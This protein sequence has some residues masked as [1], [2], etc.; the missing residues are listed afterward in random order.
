M[1][2][3][4]RI[5]GRGKQL[6][7]NP[8]VMRWVSDDRVM[9]AAEGVLD[10]RTRVKLAWH[11]LKNGHALPAVDPALDDSLGET[12]EGS[13][14][15]HAVNGSSIHGSNGAAH[16]NG[17]NGYHG[18]AASSAGSNGS[19]NG[20]HAAA[21]VARARPARENGHAN[22]VAQVAGSVD[23]EDA[24]RE[25]TGLANVG[26]HDVFEKCYQFT[27][28]DNARKAGL[29]PF[30]RPLDFNDGPEAVVDG[31]R[32]LMF[33]S[34]NYLGLTTHP[35]VRE[36][37]KAAIDRFGTS[38]TGSR[39]VN[40]SMKLHNE[41]E[42]K[43]AAFFGKESA[44]VFTTGYQVNIATCAAILSN[45][46]SVAVVDRN[47]HASLYDGVRLGQSA[48]TRLTRFKH[49]DPESLERALQRVDAGEG[50]LVITDGVFSAEGEIAKLDQIVPI[51]KRYGARLLVDDAH[52]LGVIGPGGRGTAHHFGL[53][54]DVDLIG[55][56]FSKSMA[57]IGGWL[58]GERKVL[59]Y[60]QHF[61][62]SFMFAASAAPPQVAAAMAAFDLLQE[63]AWRM[64]KLR[65]NFTFMRD[66][67]TKMGFELG[68]TQTAVIPIYIRQDLRTLMM[69]RELLEEHGVYTN[70]FIS[71][72]VP[73]KSAMLRTSYMA[74]HTREHLERGLE[75]LY[76]AGKKYGVI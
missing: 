39:L 37:A 18:A 44:L 51:V 43:L 27:A 20:A 16:V 24:L 67:L 8:A 31:R 35:K 74:T 71:P 75:A 42:E 4:S 61:A 38:M 72:G 33:G 59:E 13:N 52:A 14:G 1:G 60:I 50:A 70:P 48:G 26:G 66:E 47:V 22:G 62:P 65:E 68:H 73:P 49:A 3:K 57:S 36:A 56:T 40:G 10:A 2:L 54:D 64:D 58:V 19:V 69:W 11:M 6:V 25:R 32:V 12:I 76:K 30:F 63:E 45:K 53:S 29:Y 17:K 7:Q 46:T 28:A 21:D 34:N 55:G 9:K 41:F 15:K 5:V 23:M